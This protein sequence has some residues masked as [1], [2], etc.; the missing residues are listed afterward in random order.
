MWTHWATLTLRTRLSARASSFKHLAHHRAE[1]RTRSPQDSCCS[2]QSRDR[3]RSPSEREATRGRHE[4][5]REGER[6]RKGRNHW[7]AELCTRVTLLQMCVKSAEQSHVNRINNT[8]FPHWTCFRCRR[9]LFR[10]VLWREGD[11]GAVKQLLSVCYLFF[12]IISSGNH[13]KF[14]FFDV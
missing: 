12:F 2:A 10:T 5:D 4:R 6:E 14:L 1:T 13:G 3:E 11:L 8:D 7:K 9:A